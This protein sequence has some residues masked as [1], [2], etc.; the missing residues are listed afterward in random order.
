MFT[1]MA[2]RSV[3]ASESGNVPCP[4]STGFIVAMAKLNAGSSYVV[5]PTVIVRSWSPSRN[6][7]CDL[8]GMRLIS[9]SRITSARGERAE[10]G[11]QLA[12]GGVDHLEADHLGGL[13]VGAPLQAHELRVADRGQDDAEERLADAGHAAKQQVAGVDLALLLLVVGRR[14][15][16]QQHDVGER[17]GGLVADEGLAAFGDDLFVKGDGFFEVRM[18]GS[19]LK[20]MILSHRVRYSRFA[21]RPPPP[22]L[23][24]LS[25]R[26]NNIAVGKDGRHVYAGIAQAPGAV[27]VI[28]TK[29]MTRI[30]SIPV[31]GSIHNLYVTPDG[32][33]VVSGSIAGRMLTVI[34]AETHT[35][36]WELPTSP[37]VRP[38]TFETAPDGSTSRIFVQ[39]SDYHGVAVVDFATRKE[40]TRFELPPI[41][42][43]QKHT[44]GLQ[45]RSG[46]RARRHR[47]RQG[48]AGHQQ[49]L[50]PALRV[51]AS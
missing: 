34:D 23:R 32:K 45:G 22:P 21:F 30:A 39:L 20:A 41:P 33:H 7:L 3:A 17:L 12:G 2:N 19:A 29:T 27:D 25:G 5:L 15:L 44:E 36:A 13:Q 14:N 8:S 31:K 37:G 50:R 42:G 24:P 11:H 46:P 35:I 1:M 38:M 18:H 49:G 28:D 4:S 9:S 43:E 47:R 26:P 10:L 48:A 6:A 40:V 16:R 51:F